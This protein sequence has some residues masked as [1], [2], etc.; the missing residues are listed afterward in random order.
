M[1][2]LI[3]RRGGRI[4]LTAGISVVIGLGGFWRAAMRNSR[5][6]PD[7]PFRIAGNLYY[8]GAAGVTSFLLTGPAGDVLID[9]GYPETAPAILASLARIGVD[10][11]DVKIL[12]NTHAHFDHA[13]GLRALQDA[14]G[15]ELWISE[16]DAGIVASGGAHDPTPGP[17]R[18]LGFLGLGR[19]PSP[20]ID[21]RFN[22]GAIVRLGSIALTAHVTAGHTP[23]CTSWSF[24]V[25]DGNRDLLAV[26]VCSLT[27]LPSVSLVDPETYPGVRSDFERSFRALRDL[28][29]DVFLGSHSS[30]FNIRAKRR[31]QLAAPDGANPF[32]DPQGYRDYIDRTER[33]FR[34][35]LTEQP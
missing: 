2:G 33:T 26:D 24:L 16:R 10:I 23:G 4:A 6:T 27:L 20:R 11:H 18:Y 12:L 28:P 21:H 1:P 32:I 9:G 5:A 25:R 17:R 19:F 13:G 7:E 14:S 34:E 30:W 15:A 8:V 3:R 29:A 31:A 35:A 22:D